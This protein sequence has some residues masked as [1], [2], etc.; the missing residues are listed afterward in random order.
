M[1]ECQLAAN[2]GPYALRF[3][4]YIGDVAQPNRITVGTTMQGAC[5]NGGVTGGKAPITNVEAKFVGKLAADTTCASF[6]SAPVLQRAKLKIK[7]KNVD[8]RSR[9]VA[10]ST[11][12]LV[13]AS[14]DGPSESLVLDAELLK[15]GFA[16]S[17]VTIR[18]TIDNLANFDEDCPKFEALYYGADGESSLTVP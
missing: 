18:L 10:T 16:G 7:W 6:T 11:A 9:T 3:R 4:P 8:G 17:P 15:G 12:H 5:D 13:Q 14:W 2:A 1:I